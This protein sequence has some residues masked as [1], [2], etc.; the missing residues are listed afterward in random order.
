MSA[1][2]TDSNLKVLRLPAVIERVGLRRSAIYDMIQRDEF[3]KPLRL[4]PRARGW[5]VS[6]IDAWLASRERANAAA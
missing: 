5:L 2:N 4:S 3:P 6:E 1:V